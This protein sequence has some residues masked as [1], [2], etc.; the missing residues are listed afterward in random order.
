MPNQAV[1]TKPHRRCLSWRP[2]AHPHTPLHRPGQCHKC[3]TICRHKLHR[4]DEDRRDGF[5]SPVR[6][7]ECI[8]ALMTSPVAWVRLELIS[9]PE[10]PLAVIQGLSGDGD[11]MVA[12]TARWQM[13]HRGSPGW[14]LDIAT[15]DSG[16][17]DSDSD[18]S[19]LNDSG[20]PGW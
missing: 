5:E 14:T 16:P 10:P 7:P 19:D 1:F 12:A 18:G 15:P 4:S 6:C 9:E 3:W 2:S 20:G 8:E 17:A 13:V 11:F